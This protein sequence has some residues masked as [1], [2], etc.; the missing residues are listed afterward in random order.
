MRQRKAHTSRTVHSTACALCCTCC[1]CLCCLC[2]MCCMCYLC[3]ARCTSE[4]KHR[5]DIPS[6]ILTLC[7][8]V[9]GMGKSD[10]E[11]LRG[12][13][14]GRGEQPGTGQ[15]HS[16][17]RDKIKENDRDEQARV[18]VL[19][20]SQLL[21]CV[22]HAGAGNPV[23]SEGRWWRALCPLRPPVDLPGWNAW[24]LCCS[25]SSLRLRLALRWTLPGQSLTSGSETGRLRCLCSFARSKRVGRPS[26]DSSSR[27]VC[28]RAA[29]CTGGRP[30]HK[31]RFLTSTAT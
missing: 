14:L 8:F 21:T 30:D 28:A 4:C 12:E 31:R 27:L 13:R 18:L 22:G 6:R 16:R 19:P 3:C 5:L 29:V 2:C 24:G 25:R 9:I 23:H 10:S 20:T 1:I 17:L 15:R 26:F 7:A 11:G